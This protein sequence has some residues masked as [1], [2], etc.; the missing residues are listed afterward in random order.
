MP[1]EINRRVTDLLSDLLFVTSPEGVDN[2]ARDGRR[3]RP[4]PL[5]RQP[6]DRHAAGQPRPVRRRPR[7]GRAL[8]ARRS[9]TRSPRCTGRPTSTIPA[10]A[11]RHRRD[12][13]RAS[14]T[15]CRWSCSRSTRAA[16]RRWR[17]PACVADDRLRVVEPLGYVDFM[18]LVRGAAL[19]VTDSGG[20]QEETTILG[21]PVPDGP[22]EHRATDHD[23]PRHEPAR[24]AGGVV[25]AARDVLAGQACRR[26]PSRPAAVGRPRRRADR[27]DRPGVARR[28]RADDG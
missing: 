14:P 20:I 10:N 1:E 2:L 6:D 5:R 3:R 26:R 24:R 12:A 15:S 9:R 11:A 4:D 19:V 13:A 17:R 16:G 27:R 25:P 7:S 23:H 21:V 18:S 22:P 28:A 8:G